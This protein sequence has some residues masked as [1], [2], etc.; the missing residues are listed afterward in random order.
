MPEMD[1]RFGN[2]SFSSWSR[3]R[4]GGFFRS[5]VFA[6]P[7]QPSLIIIIIVLI[8]IISEDVVLIISHLL[9]HS[10]LYPCHINNSALASPMSLVIPVLIFIL[11]YS[12]NVFDF[13]AEHIF[14]MQK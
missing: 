9:R 14:Y 3:T 7:S 8:I 10:H 13:I 4:T 12:I 11:Y 5:S 1:L 6:W 2:F